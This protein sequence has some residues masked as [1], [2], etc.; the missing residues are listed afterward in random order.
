MEQ[1]HKEQVPAQVDRQIPEEVDEQDTRD[2]ESF[3]RIRKLES[4]PQILK[5]SRFSS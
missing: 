3:D 2:A 1:E 4:E 5:Y